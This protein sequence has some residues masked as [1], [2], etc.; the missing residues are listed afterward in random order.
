MYISLIEGIRS[1]LTHLHA[2]SATCAAVIAHRNHFLCS[3][4]RTVIVA[5]RFLKVPNLH[6]L[7]KQKSTPLPRNLALGI[8]S[9]L[10]IVVSTKV[11]LLYVLCSTIQRSCLLHLIKQNCWLKTFLR[12]LLSEVSLYLFSLLELIWNC[13]IFPSKMIKKVIINLD[14]SKASGPDCF[15]FYLFILF[16][17]F[18]L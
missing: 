8:F 1:S 3:S 12:T 5:N 6:M 17:L 15:P 9:K 18:L 4:D 14:L 16:Y 11:N 7:I 10:P 13:I 2:F